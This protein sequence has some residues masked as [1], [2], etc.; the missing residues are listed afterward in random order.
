MQDP[1]I[2]K[3]L[4]IKDKHIEVWDTQLDTREFQVCLQTIVRTYSSPKCR[5]KTKRIHSYRSQ[6]I[7]GRL[8]E[9]R[10]FI[11]HPKKRRYICTSC[12]HTFFEQLSFVDRYQRHTKSLA[13]QAMTYTA[14]LSFTEAAKL[15]GL[16]TNRVL[17]LFDNERF[18][19]RRCYH[20]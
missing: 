16:S 12:G 2:I 14:G 20:K 11:I 3:L 15:V 18:E 13:Q 1:L 5:V 17:R 19:L 10:P 8:I 7:Q 9:D 6:S 4:G